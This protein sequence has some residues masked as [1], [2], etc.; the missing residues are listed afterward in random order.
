MSNDKKRKEYETEKM[1][2]I[3]R[4]P[5]KWVKHSLLLLMINLLFLLPNIA[6]GDVAQKVEILTFS[7]ET[8]IDRKNIS[9]VVIQNDFIIIGSDEGANIQVLKKSDANTYLAEQFRIISFDNDDVEI[10]IEGLAQ[11][12][13]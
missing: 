2:A 7:G 3:K 12:K 9:G 11:S 5:R 1:T 8:E 6:L 13:K 4:K 10:D